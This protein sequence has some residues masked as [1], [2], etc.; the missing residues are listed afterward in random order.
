MFGDCLRS[1]GEK[2]KLEYIWK[3]QNQGFTSLE[4]LVIVIIYSKSA[5]T[6]YIKICD[7]CRAYVQSTLPNPFAVQS[8]DQMQSA[9]HAGE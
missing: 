8:M 5:Q 7:L 6:G 1:V 4:K 9:I 3:K 2:P